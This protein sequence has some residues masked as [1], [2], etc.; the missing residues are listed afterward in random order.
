MRFLNKLVFINSATIRYAQVMVNGNVHLIGTQGVGKSTL[1]RAILFFY[2]ADTLRLGISKEKK[3]FAEYYFPFQNAYLIYEVQRETGPYCIVAFKSQGKVCYRFIDSGYDSK[4]FISAEGLAFEK[5][6]YT[7]KF[8]NAN[9]I[10]Y[11]RKIDN[12]VEYRNIL[13]GNSDTTKREFVKYALLQSKQYQNIPR[14]IQNVFLNSKLEAEFIKQTIIM[15]LN[16]E[17]L[18]IDLQS[19]T[20][21]LKNF[22]EQLKDINEYKQPGVQKLAENIVKY[23]LAIR[24][25]DK[26]KNQLCAQLTWAIANVQ[27]LIPK[28]ND[29]K[30]KAIGDKE[31]IQQKIENAEVRFRNKAEK[32]K[33]EISVLDSDLKKAKEKTDYYNKLKIEELIERIN[34]K[35]DHETESKNLE[36]Q[37]SL[38]TAQY[39]ELSY[40][41]NALLAQLEN[42]TREFV[43]TKETEKL[44]RKNNA[45][46]EEKQ[47]RKALL[48]SV[49]NIRES[50]R[51]AVEQAMETVNQQKQNLQQEQL[52]KEG[53]K[54]QRFFEA[55]ITEA[56]Q[57]INASKLHLAQGKQSITHNKICR[58]PYKSGGNWTK[59]LLSKT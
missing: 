21:H 23:H 10:F 50:N 43:Q 46:D 7:T 27:K 38:L 51:Q 6:E 17:D 28:L 44:V 24:H 48:V 41:Y 13:Y 33:G 31:N 32:T 19:Y 29:K 26:E 54:H 45:L 34:K 35:K 22:E 30:E 14:T 40:K 53:L 52:K 57:I 9:N 4:F 1:L 55:E 47:L 20:H 2:N 5:W 58:K 37:L 56:V 25:L 36:K 11:T 39:S 18:E 12:Y 16:E 8:L 42:D 59:R 3:S 15:S 49:E